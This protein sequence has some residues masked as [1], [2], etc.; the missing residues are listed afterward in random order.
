M[1][2]QG[3]WETEGWLA[4]GRGVARTE[5]VMGWERRGLPKQAPP[6][7]GRGARQEGA[8]TPFLKGSVSLQAHMGSI[9]VAKLSTK[10]TKSQHGREWSDIFTC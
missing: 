6:V 10:E 7:E 5:G 8:A 2:H 4:V 1:Q 3:E 9:S